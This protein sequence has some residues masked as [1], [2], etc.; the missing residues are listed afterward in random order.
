M[1]TASS[2][3]AF[4]IKFLKLAKLA[5]EK[6]NLPSK[7]R[8]EFNRLFKMSVK[9]VQNLNEQVLH[10][11]LIIGGIAKVGTAAGKL[12]WGATKVVAKGSIPIG[13]SIGKG[14][15]AGV[16]GGGK[17]L[18][19]AAVG[20]LKVGA[21]VV[22]KVGTAITTELGKFAAKVFIVLTAIAAILSGVYFTILSLCSSL[23]TSTTAFF[24]T[25]FKSDSGKV[26]ID[27]ISGAKEKTDT[28][29]VNLVANAD[30]AKEQIPGIVDTIKTTTNDISTETVGALQTSARFII[31]TYDAAMLKLDQWFKIVAEYST[32]GYTEIV[33]MLKSTNPTVAVLYIALIG[34]SVV[35]I[36]LFARWLYFKVKQIIVS[37]ALTTNNIE[38]LPSKASAQ[39]AE[40][41]KH[42]AEIRKSA[43]KEIK[44]LKNKVEAI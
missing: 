1:E 10:E 21:N 16:K 9:E 2:V 43:M 36:A 28:I 18:G 34:G 17:L 11:N 22:A 5:S 13:K 27:N 8:K 7:K 44:K 15:L 14:A 32:S 37:R 42:D 23:K 6:V 12:A 24:D 26:I 30:K 39:H 41:Q 40:A 31:E 38:E 35:A 20:T 4:S 19:K 25:L 29:I 3:T 33:N